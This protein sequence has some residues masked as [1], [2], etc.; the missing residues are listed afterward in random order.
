[1]FQKGSSHL[2]ENLYL[3]GKKKKKKKIFTLIF[4][5]KF[6]NNSL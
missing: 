6:N 3:F 1:M 4:F 5:P 2:S